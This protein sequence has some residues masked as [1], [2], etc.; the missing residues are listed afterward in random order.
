MTFLVLIYVYKKMNPSRNDLSK[1]EIYDEMMD[2]MIMPNGIFNLK[3]NYEG[4]NDLRDFYRSIK[5]LGEYTKR[6]SLYNKDEVNSENETIKN[7]LEEKYGVTNPEN[8][9]N[10]YKDL[11]VEN[12]Y[13]ATID[14]KTLEKTNKGLRFYMTIDY[15]DGNIGVLYKVELLNKINPNGFVKYTFER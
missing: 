12:V 3:S 5:K 8:V 2:E 6:I 7:E 13:Y 15:N 11:K 14:S 9:I 4:D 10:Y 1:L